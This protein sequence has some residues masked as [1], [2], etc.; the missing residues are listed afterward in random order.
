MQKTDFYAKLSADKKTG[1]PVFLSTLLEPLGRPMGTQ[2]QTWS[3]WTPG[4]P[5]KTKFDIAGVDT[6]PQSSQCGQQNHQAARLGFRQFHTFYS[7]MLATP[8]M[9]FPIGMRPHLGA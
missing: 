6:C 1:V 3:K 9:L 2:N 5:D 8:E 4:V 7:H